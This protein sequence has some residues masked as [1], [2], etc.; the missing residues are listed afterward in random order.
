MAILNYVNSKMRTI[1][2][3]RQGTYVEAAQKK[4]KQFKSQSRRKW[5]K[6]LPKVG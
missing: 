1:K 6:S 3:L 2:P 5:K 4:I